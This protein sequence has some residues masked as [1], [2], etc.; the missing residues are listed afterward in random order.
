MSSRDI[1]SLKFRVGTETL[2]IHINTQCTWYDIERCDLVSVDLLPRASRQRVL[3]VKW[4]CQEHVFKGRSQNCEKRLLASSCL[5][6]FPHE[7]TRLPLD[8][9]SWNLVFEYFSKKVLRNF[10]FHWN[11]TRMT[12]TLHED[13]YTFFIV[14]RSVLIAMRHVSEK[15]CWGNKNTHFVYNNVFFKKIVSSSSSSC[16][17]RVRRVS[18]SLILKMKLVPPSL[19]RSTYVP[20]SFWFIL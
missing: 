11:R 20:L 17:W 9:F 6:V 12:G 1:H 2:P 15:I 4:N 5:S 8:G 19:P 14:S 13:K 7:T 3:I 18:Y 16:S 10:T